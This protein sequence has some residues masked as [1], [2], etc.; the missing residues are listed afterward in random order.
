MSIP[1]EQLVLAEN[2]EKGLMYQS[3]GK[4]DTIIENPKFWFH[5][6]QD[7][8]LFKGLKGYCACALGFG[9]IGRYGSPIK[10]KE[11]IKRIQ[12]PVNKRS[13]ITGLGISKGLFD[14]VDELHRD[15]RLSAKQIVNV[16]RTRSLV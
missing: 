3:H 2:I 13:M 15:K 7:D 9:L 8:Q 12:Y 6:L 14:A 4:E 10:A 11:A 5:D 16:L 1:R